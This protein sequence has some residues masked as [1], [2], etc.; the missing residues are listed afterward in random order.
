M[1]RNYKR[2]FLFSLIITSLITFFFLHAIFSENGMRNIQH[3]QRE[4]ELKERVMR[5]KENQVK[6]LEIQVETLYTSSHVMSVMNKVGYGVKGGDVYIFPYEA[7]NQ[8]QVEVPTPLKKEI[9]V[10]NSFQLFFISFIFSMIIHILLYVL[11]QNM[12]RKKKKKHHILG[13]NDESYTIY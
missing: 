8:A 13:E 3:I 4:I 2:K 11:M 6:E 9:V 5:E 10:L 7:H 12:K 1:T